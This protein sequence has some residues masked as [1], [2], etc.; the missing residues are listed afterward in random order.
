MDLL[1]RRDHFARQVLTVS[2]KGVVVVVCITHHQNAIKVLNVSSVLTV[3]DV[4]SVVVCRILCQH[5]SERTALQVMKIPLDGKSPWPSEFQPR[6][7]ASF[8][9]LGLCHAV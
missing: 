5:T 3:V 7:A 9:R 6:E 2:G 1:L 4:V 8:A